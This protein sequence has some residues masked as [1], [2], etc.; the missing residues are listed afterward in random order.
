MKKTFTLLSLAMIS[1]VLI[2]AACSKSDGPVSDDGTDTTS[3]SSWKFGS[4]TYARGGSSQDDNAGGNDPGDFVALTVSTSG[5]GGDYGAFSGSALVF[6]FPNYLGAGK[7]TL[8]DNLDL[9]TNKGSMLMEVNCTIG[10]AVNTGA[11]QYTTNKVNGGSATLTIDA[12]GKYHISIDN[13]VI[14]TKNVEVGGG[15]TGAADTYALT[16]KD[17]Y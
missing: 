17:A 3:D 1:F 16:V 9:V 2:F 14:L 4:Y 15:I 11:V 8:T 5:D 10:T 12:K 7:Y 6:T 13:A